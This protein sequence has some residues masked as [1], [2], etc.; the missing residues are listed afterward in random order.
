MS[1]LKKFFYY[2]VGFAFG[3][4]LVIFIWRGKGVSFDYGMNAR[5]LKTLRAKPLVYSEN[6]Q[7]S[8]KKLRI[9]STAIQSLLVNGDVNFRKSNPRGYPCP[10]YF[11]TGTYSK[12]ELQMYIIRCDSTATVSKIALKEE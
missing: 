9:D 12:N 1:V 7:L 8:M 6:A 5:T 4:V 10:E 2:L 11:I 3:I